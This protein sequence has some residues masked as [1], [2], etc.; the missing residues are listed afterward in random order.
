MAMN[1]F[2]PGYPVVTSTA[3][4]ITAT[5]GGTQVNAFQLTARVNRV[6]TVATAGDAVRLPPFMAD[7]PCFVS[8]DS[9]NALAVYP[10]EGG[11]M[12]GTLPAGTNLVI[13]PGKVVSF[14]GTGTVGRWIA[15]QGA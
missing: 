15:L 4:N 14:I 8:N 1:N 6:V 3:E 12:I 7:G 2:T 5:P 13:P 9:L 11:T 10:Y